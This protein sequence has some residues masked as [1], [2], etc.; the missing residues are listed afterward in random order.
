MQ[1]TANWLMLSI[2]WWLCTTVHW[3][4]A[5]GWQPLPMGD[6]TLTH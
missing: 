5:T 4:E 2:Q 1:D 6:P 3:L